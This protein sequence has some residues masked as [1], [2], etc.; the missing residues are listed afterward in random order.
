VNGLGKKLVRDRYSDTQIDHFCPGCG[1]NHGVAAGA[2]SEGLSRRPFRFTWSEVMEAIDVK[3]YQCLIAP[4]PSRKPLTSPAGAIPGLRFTVWQ[5]AKALKA[6]D[7]FW[8]AGSPYS[9][10]PDDLYTARYE[11]L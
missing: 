8:Y 11:T 4:R 3:F 10:D 5:A 1:H 6:D 2:Q 9:R 7:G